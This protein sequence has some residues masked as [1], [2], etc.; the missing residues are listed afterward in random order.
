MHKAFFIN[1][2]L[3][4]GKEII[5]NE[6]IIKWSEKF[7]LLFYVTIFENFATTIYANFINFIV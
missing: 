7:V 4:P 3:I 2:N 6:K 5:I 1:E